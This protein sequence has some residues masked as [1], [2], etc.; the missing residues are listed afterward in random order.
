MYPG[1]SLY[2]DTAYS[3]RLLNFLF[4][5]CFL[6]GGYKP[7]LPHYVVTTSL[8]NKLITRFDFLECIECERMIL[9]HLTRSL[10]LESGEPETKEIHILDF[11]FEFFLCLRLW[12]DTKYLLLKGCV[13]DSHINEL[14]LNRSTYT[15]SVF[16]RDQALFS[17]VLSQISIVFLYT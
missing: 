11:F 15:N 17:I 14:V 3:Q 2:T 13:T 5:H 12:S 8:H 6:N 7:S 10:S 1:S 9:M 4:V 16:A